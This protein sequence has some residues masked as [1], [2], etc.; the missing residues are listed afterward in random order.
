[1][2]NKLN[3]EWL[4][5]AF[6]RAIKTVAQTA[7]GML[8]V[9]AAIN[10]IAWSYVISVSAVAGVLSML[11]SIATTLPE[12]GCGCAYDG[13]LKIDTTDPLKDTYRLDLDSEVEKLKDQTSIKL[14]I[15]PNAILPK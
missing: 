15:D 10:E 3:L 6:H 9:G 13:T 2:K 5:A 12:V 7:V 4:L 1:M 14:K 8:T 11:T